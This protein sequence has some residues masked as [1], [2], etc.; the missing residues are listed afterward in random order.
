MSDWT[1]ATIKVSGSLKKQPLSGVRHNVHEGF[2]GIDREDEC[3]RRQ[4]DP[5]GGQVKD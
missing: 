3:Q 4:R 1:P 2:A 5:Q